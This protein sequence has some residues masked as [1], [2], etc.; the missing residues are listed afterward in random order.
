MGIVLKLSLLHL[1][2]NA[3]ALSILSLKWGMN[4]LLEWLEKAKCLV[5]ICIGKKQM[6]GSGLE[7]I[8]LSDGL[9]EIQRFS[10]H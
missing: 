4:H 10:R 2:Q 7:Q 9:V 3:I 1:L 8:M 5:L 6:F